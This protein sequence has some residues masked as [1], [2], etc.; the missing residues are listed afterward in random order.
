M[1]EKPPPPWIALPD[2]LRDNE[3]SPEHIKRFWDWYMF[4]YA[5][6]PD[7][8]DA[9]ERDFPAPPDWAVIYQDARRFRDLQKDQSAKM[10]GILLIE[11]MWQYT[12]F[13]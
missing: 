12:T 7:E 6:S 3:T 8:L 9:Y 13:K 11:K 1:G 10:W 4:L 5:L 2:F